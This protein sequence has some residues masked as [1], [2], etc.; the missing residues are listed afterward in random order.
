MNAVARAAT[1]ILPTAESAGL[2]DRLISEISGL[3]SQDSAAVWARE[4]LPIKNTLTAADARFV[5]TAFALRQSAFSLSNNG[6]LA[7][8]NLP[9]MLA[10][11]DA[12]PTAA[13]AAT[14]V[15]PPA[16]AARVEL[17]MKFLLSKP[18]GGSISADEHGAAR[19][20]KSVFTISTPK[21]H[22][23]KEH[24][25]FVAQQT[26]V[27]CGRKPSEAHH[28]RF[29]QPRA[30]GRK[31]S[32]EFAVP[33]Y[34]AQHRAVHRA[35]DEKAW[36]QQ[37]VIDPLKIA[38]KLWKLTRLGEP[39]IRSATPAQ[40]T[41]TQPVTEGGGRKSEALFV[42]TR[43]LGLLIRAFLV[44]ACDSPTGAPSSSPSERRSTSCDR[45]VRCSH[46]CAGLTPPTAPSISPARP[47]INVPV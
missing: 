15:C 47:V 32:D 7:A 18:V 43:S 16:A 21:R 5:E 31:P 40:A 35:G 12:P 3:D 10:M 42:A 37:A 38:R 41:V 11:A 44:F 8:Q 19:I 26:C 34:R 9:L 36:W 13:S 46:P 20:D 6:K 27:L 29:V 24:L 45:A 22:R 25:R 2:R 28:I 14:A 30:L 23:S 1:S 33:L 4:A 17:V 39:R